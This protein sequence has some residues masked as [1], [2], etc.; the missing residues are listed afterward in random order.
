MA[1]SLLRIR[2]PLSIEAHLSQ[3]QSTTD[4]ETGFIS[5]TFLG[6]RFTLD[7]LVAKKGSRGRSS[8]VKDHGIFVRELLS[9]DTLGMVATLTRAIS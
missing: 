3:L 5:T 9:G 6:R 1:L 7:S 8:W 2:R 4:T